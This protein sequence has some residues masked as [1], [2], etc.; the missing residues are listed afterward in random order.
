MEHYLGLIQDFTYDD[1]QEKRGLRGEG[2]VLWSA[3]DLRVQ[4]RAS[5]I[6]A[7]YITRVA[8]KA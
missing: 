8:W 7:N 4:G 6:N 1:V 3:Q 2:E 5:R